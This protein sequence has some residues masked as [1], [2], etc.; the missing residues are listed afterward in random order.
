MGFERGETALD[1]YT[2]HRLS[3]ALGVT[4]PAMLE[5][6]IRAYEERITVSEPDRETQEA[7]ELIRRFLHVEGASRGEKFIHLVNEL[8][9][10]D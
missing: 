2:L 1:V 5:A 7:G 3:T 10:D 6:A 9:K 4:T 8:K